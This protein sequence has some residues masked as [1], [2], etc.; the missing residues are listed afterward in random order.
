MS[1]DVG[2]HQMW[3]AQ[4]C[5]FAHPRNHLTSGALGTMGFGLP[6]AM[7]AQFACPDR[8][9]VLVNGDGGFMMNV[10]ELVTIARCR[11]PIKMVLLDNSSL[12][13]VRQ[14]QELFFDK[15]YSEI[16]LSD[17]PDFAALAQVCGIP[18]SRIE[19]RDQVEG[20]LAGLLATPGPALLHVK[21]DARANVWPLVPPNTANSQMLES[22][23]NEK[24]AES[25]HALPA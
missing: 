15:R 8:T 20:A 16:D 12:G 18:A 5:R 1:S 13:M 21:I 9:V 4:H 24:K 11:L 7:G 17:N 10:Q 19:H 14:W 22:N 23:P 25:A 3:V 2:Q 6:A